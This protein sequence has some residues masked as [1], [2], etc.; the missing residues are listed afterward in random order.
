MKKII[1]F[2]LSAIMLI[3]IIT[4]INISAYAVSAGVCGENAVWIFDSSTGTLTISG[5]GKVEMVYTQTRCKYGK[6]NV[7]NIIIEEEITEIEDGAFYRYNELKNVSIQNGLTKIGS[8]AFAYC[9]KLASICISSSVETIGDIAFYC[10][11]NLTSVTIGNGVKSIGVGAFH[12]CTNLQNVFYAGREEE[13]NNI[14]V[15][16]ENEWLFNANIHYMSYLADNAAFLAAIDEAY[17]YKRADYTKET[18]DNL[19]SVIDKYAYL[20]STSVDQVIYD[21]ATS[22]IISAIGKLDAYSNYNLVGIHG[23][24]VFVSKNGI[25]STMSFNEYCNMDC[26][27]LDVVEDGVV[28]AKD[29]AYLLK[30]HSVQS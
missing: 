16:E 23:N 17:S 30:N 27:I 18:F 21:L 22:E 9:G 13:W 11:S 29:Y 19:C 24:I 10:C 7:K 14:E 25:V 2:F 1:S 5:E 3:G 28:N 4:G 8:G 15:A 20:E 6:S 12:E 26:S